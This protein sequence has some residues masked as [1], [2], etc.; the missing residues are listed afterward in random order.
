MSI[1]GWWHDSSKMKQLVRYGLVGI[2][3]N[4]S[5]YL[6]YLLITFLGLEA[7]AAMTLVYF[8]G[9]TIGFIGN[10]KWTF[11][12]QGDAHGAAI[13]YVIAHALGY[14][15][16]FLLLLGLVDHLGY[17]HQLVQAFAIVVVAAFLFVT[18]KL[19]VFREKW[20]HQAAD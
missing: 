19:W 13:R 15:I 9:A 5:I 2:A 18:F 17:P 10:R 4:L 16:N 20:L 14:L 6:V 12:H 7:K 11:D 3:S 1:T 8:I